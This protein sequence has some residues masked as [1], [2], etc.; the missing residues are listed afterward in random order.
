MRQQLFCPQ[1]AQTFSLP[2]NLTKPCKFTK[3]NNALFNEPSELLLPFRV[4][5]DSGFLLQQPDQEKPSFQIEPR[6]VKC[7][8]PCES[9]VEND[10]H[11]DSLK[12]CGGYEEDF[13]TESILDEEIEDGVD[14]IMGNLSVNNA[15]PDEASVASCS[16]QILTWCCPQMGLGFG[17][18]WDLSFWMRRDIKGMRH[19]D[20]EEWWRF[21]PV[22]VLDISPKFSKR[23]TEKKKK[24]IEKPVEKSTKSRKG[25]SRP[26]LLLKLNYKEILNA[27]SDRGTPFSKEIPG[28]EKSGRDLRGRGG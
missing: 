15:S 3:L 6:V 12:L 21:P 26:K 11:V 2:K 27:W 8:K 9:P 7:E 24:K 5:D 23:T 22:N 10:F 25:N 16:G 20:E 19:T 14:S 1:Y 4:I 17:G 28:H 13:D 18:H